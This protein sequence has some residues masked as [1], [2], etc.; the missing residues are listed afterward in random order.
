[1]PAKDIYHQVVKQALIKANWTI[2][3]APYPLS[4]AKRN[5]YIDLGAEQL[6]AAEKQNLKIAVEVKSFLNVLNLLFTILKRRKFYNGFH[7]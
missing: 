7:K 5:I 3:H 4:W 6:L 2:T 1:M